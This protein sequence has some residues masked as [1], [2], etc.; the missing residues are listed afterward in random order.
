MSSSWSCLACG[1]MCSGLGGISAS[2]STESIFEGGGGV[3]MLVAALIAEAPLPLSLEHSS[4]KR[5]SSR[6]ISIVGWKY[7]IGRRGCCGM[8]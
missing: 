5:I 6:G 2:S 8:G 4:L 7:G 1:R 3:T